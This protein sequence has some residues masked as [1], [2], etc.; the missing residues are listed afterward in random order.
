MQDRKHLFPHKLLTDILCLPGLGAVYWELVACKGEAK[1]LAV[2]QKCCKTA[3]KFGAIGW[4]YSGGQGCLMMQNIKE[5]EILNSVSRVSLD[6]SHTAHH[7]MTDQLGHS[8]F[9]KTLSMLPLY[10]RESSTVS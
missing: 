9:F 8:K 2:V 5:S 4:Q 7:E 1:H 6:S 10:S 3:R